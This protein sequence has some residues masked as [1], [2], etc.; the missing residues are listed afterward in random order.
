VGFLAAGHPDGEAGVARAAGDAGTI[1]FVSGV[2]TTP[3]EEIMAAA[4]GPVYYQ[5]YYIGGRDASAP[6]LERVRRA[7]VSGLV[8]TVD[9]PT[10]ARPK[11]RPWYDRAEVPSAVDLKGMLTFAPQLVTK[12]PWALDMLRSG[13]AKMPD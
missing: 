7:G 3:I 9:T 11:D 4:S 8:L 5:L 2:T 6:I 10:I 1:Q 13:K 12:L